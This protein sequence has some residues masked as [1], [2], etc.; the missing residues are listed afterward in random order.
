[1][2]FLIFPIDA[3]SLPAYLTHTLSLRLRSDNH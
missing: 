3:D 2:A 1:L